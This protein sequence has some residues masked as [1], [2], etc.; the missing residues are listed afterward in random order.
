LRLSKLIDLAYPRGIYCASCGAIIEP[1][2]KY[3]LCGS[4]RE[5]FKFATNN[6]CKVCGRVLD[7]NSNREICE[8]CEEGR[9]FTKSYVCLTYG[10]RERELIL[11]FKYNGK[12]FLKDCLSEMMADR[13]L[14]EGAPDYDLIVPVP[15]FEKNLNKRGYNQSMLLAKPIA[16]KLGIELADVLIKTKHNIS[17][18]KLEKYERR[19]NVKGSFALRDCDKIKGKRILLID[20][21]LTTGSTADEISCLLLENGASEVYCLFLAAP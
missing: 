6:L 18:N 8:E 11:S 21:I 4:C 10:K 5:K 9:L 15:V 1:E 19:M 20:D 3:E 13:L 2:T 7:E 17:M 12:A 16:K 14:A